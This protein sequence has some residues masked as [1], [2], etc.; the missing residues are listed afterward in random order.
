MTQEATII[1]NLSR[2][3]LIEKFLGDIV[4]QRLGI[5]GYE[6]GILTAQL[7]DEH[8]K[9]DMQR[10][11]QALTVGGSNCKSFEWIFHIGKL[12]QNQ[13]IADARILDMLAEVRAFEFLYNIGVKNTS[14]LSQ[15]SKSTTV[16]FV[17]EIGNDR[18]AVEVT[19]IGLPKSTKKKSIFIAEDSE[20]IKLKNRELDVTWSLISGEDN[21]PTFKKTIGDAIDAKY[22]QVKQF[23][24]IQSETWK[25]VITISF[26]RDYFV[27]KYARRDLS[28][29]PEKIKE[30][31]EMIWREQKN[32]YKYLDYV[33][34]LLGKNLDRAFIYPDLPI[35]GIAT[36]G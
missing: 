14:Y 25:G 27:T 23:C 17:T 28:I 19:R 9:S 1:A 10:L 7:L 35:K 30:A 36:Y 18:N 22:L 20:R 33:I 8:Y 5:E 32:V 6:N 15:K 13:E 31:I 4:R 26:G 24:Q 16:D 2:Y 34:F 21:R 3:P 12:P 29:F 11:E